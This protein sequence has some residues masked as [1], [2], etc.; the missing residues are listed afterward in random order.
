MYRINKY[1]ICKNH[2]IT[3]TPTNKQKIYIKKQIHKM[4]KM[5]S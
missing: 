2:Q 5:M 4:N 1:L 3:P